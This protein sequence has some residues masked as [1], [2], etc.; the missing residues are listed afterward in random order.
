LDG[1]HSS[2]ILLSFHPTPKR[3]R[4]LPRPCS[5]SRNIIT[6]HR[7]SILDL[8]ILMISNRLRLLL[9]ASGKAFSFAKACATTPHGEADLSNQLC[10]CESAEGRAFTDLSKE[11]PFPMKLLPSHRIYHKANQAVR[12]RPDGT[13]ACRD[14]MQLEAMVPP[15]GFK[16]KGM[17]TGFSIAI[18]PQF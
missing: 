3:R 10:S 12:L 2:I 4:C 7:T 9:L 13:M 16:L 18:F 14:G 5:A 1:Q 6:K 11:L 15:Q 8:R 17:I